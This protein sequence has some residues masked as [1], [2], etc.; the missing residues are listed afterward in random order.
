MAANEAPRSGSDPE[1]LANIG[2]FTGIG[3][4]ILSLTVCVPIVNW[5]TCFLA[6]LAGIAAI[7]MSLMA[8]NN[9]GP[10]AT[11]QAADR[12]RYGLYLGIGSLVVYGIALAI[13]LLI[14]LSFGALDTL[15]QGF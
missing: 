8:R 3:G 11:G 6:P 7:V 10:E 2:F 5:C 15:Q 14:G 9:L 4:A 12:S 1:Q 13:G